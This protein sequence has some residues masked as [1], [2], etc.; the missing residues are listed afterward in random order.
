MSSNVEIVEVSPLKKK[1]R[2]VITGFTGPGF[3]GNT[4]LMYIVRNKGLKLRVLLRSHLIPPIML[5]IE[6]RP[7]PAFRIYCDEKDELLFLI[8]DAMIAAENAWPIGIRLTEWLRDKGVREIVSIEGLPF[9][10]PSEERTIFGF[11]T[12]YRDLR[13]YDIRLTS[14]GGVSGLS[15]VMLDESLRNELPW[16]SLFVYTSLVS[17]IDYG[18][19]AAIIQALNRM[20][21]LGVD[22][23]P[24]EKSDEVRRQMIERSRGRGSRGFLSSLRRRFPSDSG[25]A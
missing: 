6:G 18:G 23:E 14:E 1:K 12:P 8:S 3:I 10:T 16:V 22:V 4:A 5:L 19:A 15:A 25:A 20:F 9:G 17:V 11:S 13:Q 21:K 2:T 7:T 24:L